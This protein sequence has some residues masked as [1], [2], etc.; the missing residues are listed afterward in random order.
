MSNIVVVT[1]YKFF[2][3]TDCRERRVPIQT[4]CDENGIKGTILLATEG[5][6]ST[7]A[8]TREGIDTVLHYLRED[9][10]L[11]DLTWKESYHDEIPFY[12]M[13]VKVKREIVSLGMPEVNPNKKK[14]GTYVPPQE[15]NTVI[16]DP[17]VLV[18]DTRN[19]F[20][21]QVGTFQRAVNPHTKSFREFPTYVQQELDPQKYKKVAMFCTGGIRC[22]KAT[23]YMLENG[24]EQ[25]Y[26]LQGG[27]LQY[28]ADV[29]EEESLWQGECFVFDERVSVDHHLKKGVYELC[30]GCHHPLTPADRQ[31]PHYE[32]GVCCP[33]CHDTLSEDKKARA[34]ERQKQIRLAKE[35]GETHIG[36]RFEPSK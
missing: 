10:R 21:Y 31:S 11:A 2:D 27:I 24:F 15:W 36:R 13:K 19:S 35:R 1:F 16:S 3:F 29:P 18:I 25:V 12:R 7:I 20:E 34:R 33:Y 22:E 8:G 17:E 6:N 4:V 30:Y 9:P 26:H 32:E 28:L 14:V 23:A 5:I